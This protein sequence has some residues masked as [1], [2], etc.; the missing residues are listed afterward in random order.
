MLTCF[1]GKGEFFMLQNLKLKAIF[2]LFAGGGLALAWLVE[3]HIIVVWLA[4]ATIFATLL[5]AHL[6]TPG[7]LPGPWRLIKESLGLERKKSGEKVRRSRAKPDKKSKKTKNR[8]SKT[9]I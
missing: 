2:L 3:R 6:H 1:I 5:Y 7:G 8:H 4:V 9:L